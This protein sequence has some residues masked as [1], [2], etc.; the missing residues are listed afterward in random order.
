VPE[1]RLMA[2]IARHLPPPFPAA[3]YWNR[4]LFLGLAPLLMGAVV[5]LAG[6]QRRGLR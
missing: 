5:W 2:D 3:F 1:R 6:R 4:A